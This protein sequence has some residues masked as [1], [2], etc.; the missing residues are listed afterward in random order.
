MPLIDDHDLRSLVEATFDEVVDVRRDLHAHP[1]LSHQEERTTAVVRDL[2]AD[3]GWEELPCPTPTGAVFAL[4]VD[5]PGPTVLLRADIDALPV[6]EEVSVSYRSRRQGV[7]H[8]CGHDAHTAVLVGVA[9]VLT[10]RAEA[11][12]GR[13]VAVFQP[14]EETFDGAASML[15]GGLLEHLRPDYVVGLHVASTL[16]SGVV[17]ARPGVAMA[18]AQPIRVRLAG[19]GGHAA[20]G[21]AQG[22]PLLAAAGLASRLGECVSGLEWEEVPCIATAGLLRA[23]TAANVVPREA[24]VE[25][26]IRV[27]DETQRRTAIDRLRALGA[28]IGIEHGVAVEIDLPR[29]VPA[30]VND[31]AVTD[32]VQRAA[33]RLLGPDRVTAMPPA[34]PSDDVAEFLRVVPGCYFFVGAASGPG[35][36]T[37]HHAPD[38]AIDEGALRPAMLTLAAAAIDLLAAPEGHRRPRI[39]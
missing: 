15:A 34:T 39:P 1:E 18:I 16:Q 3:L 30:V 2:V 12:P 24:V 35:R 38:F 6:D 19:R 27:F 22:N 4:S 37:M 26:S 36:P 28:E 7:M 9:T 31:P 8:A 5:R 25:G 32:V 17:A 33:S 23:G 21:G 13:L 29:A 10:R 11:L 20:V 14:G